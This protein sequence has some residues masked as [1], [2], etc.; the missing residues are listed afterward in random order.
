MDDDAILLAFIQEAIRQGSYFF[1][2]VTCTV[3]ESGD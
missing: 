2:T 3:G 1:V